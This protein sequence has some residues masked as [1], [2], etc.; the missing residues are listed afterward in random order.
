MKKKISK[1][2]RYGILV[3]VG[4][5]LIYPLLFMITGTVKS[6]QE[7]FTSL[8]LWPQD[9]TT[10]F[11]DVLKEAWDT[12]SQYTMTTYFKNSFIMVGG[13]I[14]GTVISSV[15][16][17]YAIA[18]FDFK[19]KKLVF[20]LVIA[21]LII[22]ISLFTIPLFILWSNLGFTDS[23]VPLIV[24]SFFATNSFLIFMLIQF[25]RTIP[26]TLD[27]AAILDGC[28]SFTTLTKVLVPIIKPTV[29]TMI[30]LTFVWGMADFQGPLIYISTASKFPVTLALK[31][32]IDADSSVQYNLVFAMSL[33]SLLPSI[34]VFF[35]AQKYF[36]E[37]IA[38]GSIKG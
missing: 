21:T 5:L 2:L 31:L 25:F 12:G 10:N 30:L 24:P 23:F 38:S 33:I 18:R 4:I 3:T 29:V 6:N 8:S 22:P 1:F 11:F 26:K 32:I 14:I 34:I 19:G 27:E 36:V 28:N 35:M 20:S 16:T 17:A 9:P 13:Q 7:I 15:P 37:G